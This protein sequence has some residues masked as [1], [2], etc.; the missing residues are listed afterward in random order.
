MGPK[1]TREQMLA[2]A[3]DVAFDEGL[4]H[5]TFGRVAAR[6]GVSDRTVVYYLPTK[7]DLITQ[8][9]LEVG[10]RLQVVLAA[11]FTGP[12]TDHLEL[13]RQAWPVLSRDEFDPV[14]ALYFEAIGFA[15]AGRE[16]YRTLVAQLVD[17]WATWLTG[18]L[19]GTPTARRTEAE[20]AITLIDGL[21]LL[22]QISG[23]SS[24]AR[25]ARRLGVTGPGRR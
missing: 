8:V 9:L 5:L 11:A 17:G 12:A 19:T 18:F 22:R 3:V 2:G 14:F 15:A 21:L 20:S 13:A 10:T 1:H 6:T 16:P 24:S 7:D 25:V 23:P 4:S